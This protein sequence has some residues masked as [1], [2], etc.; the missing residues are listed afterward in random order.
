MSAN[1]KQFCRGYF[2]YS[3]EKTVRITYWILNLQYFP[4]WCISEQPV[5][6]GWSKTLVDNTLLFS[7]MFGLAYWPPFWQLFLDFCQMYFASTF[8]RDYQSSKKPK[9]VY[10]SASKIILRNIFVYLIDC[11]QVLL[12]S[13]VNPFF[14]SKY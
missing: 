9:S 1:V 6:P 12:I 5:N 2:Q 3:T 11:V 8:P 14:N 4:T 10:I 7:R 13:V